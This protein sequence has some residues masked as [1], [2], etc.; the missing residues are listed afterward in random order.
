MKIQTYE[1]YKNGMHTL[2]AVEDNELGSPLPGWFP[3]EEKRIETYY[4]FRPLVEK[5]NR[6]E[7]SFE[8]PL[9]R[10]LRDRAVQS[11]HKARRID[12][13]WDEKPLQLRIDPPEL[14]NPF[15]NSY[16]KSPLDEAY[17][18]AYRMR[19]LLDRFR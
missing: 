14:Q 4:G 7:G 11:L 13:L 17:A 15:N 18:H 10:T 2:I 3:E 12:S 6:Q 19:V 16:G 9:Q 8:L 5:M 1:N